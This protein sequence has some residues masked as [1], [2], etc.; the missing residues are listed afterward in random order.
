MLAALKADLAAAK[1]YL[2]THYKQLALAAVL[3]KFSSAIVAAVVALVH[4]L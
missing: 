3:G 1:A 4:A 2:V